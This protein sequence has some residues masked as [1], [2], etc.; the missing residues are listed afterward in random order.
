M[1]AN[2]KGATVKG[3]GSEAEAPPRRVQKPRAPTPPHREESSDSDVPEVPEEVPE[4]LQEDI[5][6]PEGAPSQTAR[7]KEM[8][9]RGAFKLKDQKGDAIVI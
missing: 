6:A 4:V 8:K 3:K 1:P 9:P 5:P 7:R 2:R